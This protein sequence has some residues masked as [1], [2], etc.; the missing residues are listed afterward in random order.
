MEA[1]WRDRPPMS[2][3][4]LLASL[5]RTLAA[6][7]REV[8]E[9]IVLE[10]IEGLI[11]AFVRENLEDCTDIT[12]NPQLAKPL[13]AMEDLTDLLG[14][15]G[16]TAVEYT[17]RKHVRS[18]VG[19]YVGQVNTARPIAVKDKAKFVEHMECIGL[20]ISR[21]QDSGFR[22]LMPDGNVVV[23]AILTLALAALILARTTRASK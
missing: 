4:L 20:S 2:Y 19:C 23:M 15:A 9:A 22:R 3:E 13:L 17:L 16:A 5:S 14:G 8:R 21:S 11:C 7:S 6:A 18:V 1:D 10:G 12:Y